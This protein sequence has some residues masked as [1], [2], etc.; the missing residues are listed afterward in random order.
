[1]FHKNY[2]ISQ[3]KTYRYLHIC[4]HIL[5]TSYKCIKQ[6]NKFVNRSHALY[7][8]KI[9]ML[10]QNFQRVR[11]SYPGE[12]HHQHL[13]FTLLVHFDLLVGI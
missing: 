6:I 5:D 10:Q 9:K 7:L 13:I 1:M 12:C 8:C 3:R 11:H 4:S 2:Q